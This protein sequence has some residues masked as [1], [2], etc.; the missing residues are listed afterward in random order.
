MGPELAQNSSETDRLLGQGDAAA[1]GHL[2]DRHRGRLRRMLALRL[3]HRLQGRIDPSDVIQETYLEATER[4]DEYFRQRTMPFYLWLRFLAGQRLLILHRR[5]LGA[6]VRDASREVTLVRGAMPEASS[7]AL[8][9]H[10]LG[11]ECRPSEVAIRAEIKLRLQEALNEMEPLDREVLALRHFEQLTNGE[12]ARVLRINQA[13]A[14]KR[15]VRALRKLK[16]ILA[17]RPGG[18][19]EWLS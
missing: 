9:A 1:W 13:A 10:L 11:R 3:D 18:L 6:Q 7:A 2:L 19:G 5:H 12:T 16:E 4:K 15:Y 8:A 17:S 14:S